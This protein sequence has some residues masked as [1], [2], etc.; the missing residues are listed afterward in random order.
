VVQCWCLPCSYTVV[1]CVGTC[2]LQLQDWLWRRKQYVPP[3]RRKTTY[4]YNVQMA[5]SRLN[6]NSTYLLFLTR[7]SVWRDEKCI[8]N[9]K[10]CGRQREARHYSGIC[11]EGLRKAT[12]ILSQDNPCFGRVNNP[13]NHNIHSYFSKKQFTTSLLPTSRVQCSIFTRGL[14]TNG[15]FPSRLLQVLS[16]ATFWFNYL[17]NARRRIQIIRGPVL[18]LKFSLLW[19]WIICFFWVAR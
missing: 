3:K 12:K 6:F 4:F 7:R 18:D 8:M 15:L 9:W 13:E 5:K 11:L 2:C 16:I 17:N 1:L 19:Q 14:P 10:G